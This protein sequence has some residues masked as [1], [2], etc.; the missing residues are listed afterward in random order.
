MPAYLT[1]AIIGNTIYNNAHK[2]ESL[3]KINIPLPTLKASTLSPDLAKL[4]KSDIN[5][6]N[7]D[8]DLYFF[9]MIE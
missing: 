8:T 3:F 1:H 5:S 7:K 4:S 2:D 6:H 9:N